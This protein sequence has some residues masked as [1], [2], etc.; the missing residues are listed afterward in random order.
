MERELEGEAMTTI[1]PYLDVY[2]VPSH[3][4]SKRIV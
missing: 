3:Y 4:L 2:G 1:K